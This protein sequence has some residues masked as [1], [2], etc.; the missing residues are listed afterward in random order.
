MYACMSFDFDWSMERLEKK[1][2]TNEA[3]N[4]TIF[5]V[6]FRVAFIPFKRTF[7]FFQ[8]SLSGNRKTFHSSTRLYR[9][10]RFQYW[11]GARKQ[12]LK[13]PIF[14]HLANTSE[15]RRKR[16]KIVTLQRQHCQSQTFHFLIA[17]PEMKTLELK[18]KRRKERKKKWP[19]AKNLFFSIL[20]SFLSQARHEF[21]FISFWL[22]DCHRQFSKNRLKRKYQSKSRW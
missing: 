1:R 20:Q 13:F 22:C 5:Y 19:R 7:S 12:L 11:R 16:L 14:L 17:L 8:F 18:K 6:L 9:N 4:W 10:V 2:W 3:E 15:R 21:D